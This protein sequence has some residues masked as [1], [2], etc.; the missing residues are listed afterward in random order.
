MS[1]LFPHFANLS[2]QLIS[3]HQG[4]CTLVAPTPGGGSPI[5]PKGIISKGLSQR[6]GEAEV[7]HKH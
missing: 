3:H 4:Y 5:P 1:I 6:P 7:S 2:V